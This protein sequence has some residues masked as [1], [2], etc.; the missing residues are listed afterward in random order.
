MRAQYHQQKKYENSV[1]GLHSNGC[2]DI[3]SVLTMDSGV[4]RL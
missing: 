2:D 1:T 4:A 3:S